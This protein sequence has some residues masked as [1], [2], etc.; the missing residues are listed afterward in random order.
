MTHD[1]TAGAIRQSI[2]RFNDYSNDL[3]GADM[4]SF[5]DRLNML[6]TFCKEDSV[7]SVIHQQLTAA[8]GVNFTIWYAEAV[9]SIGGMAGS[10]TLKF[11]T[12]AEARM[13]LM[14]QLLTNIHSK[15]IDLLDFCVKFFATGSNKVDAYI[16]AFNKNISIPLFRELS[17][18]LTDL[19][20][21]LPQEKQNTVPAASVQIIHHAQN[22]IQQTATGSNINQ[23]ATQNINTKVEAILDAIEKEL[24]NVSDASIKEDGLVILESVRAE[25]RKEKPKTQVVMALLN[26]LPV[27]AP[28]LELSKLALAA[29]MN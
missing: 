7:F 14:Y 20:D 21:S 12:G 8:Q 9:Q 15:K 16:H 27:I 6:L 24:L 5:D 19:K 2:Q 10:G 23:T 29:L 3:V 17:Y 22:V 1:F 13:A 26:A 4:G 11:P 28:I 25:T 18:R